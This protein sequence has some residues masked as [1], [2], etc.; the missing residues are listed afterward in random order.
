[1]PINSVNTENNV[2]VPYKSENPK[3][4]NK[5]DNFYDMEIPI[6]KK[7]EKEMSP[8]DKKQQEI[9]DATK[10]ATEEIESSIKIGRDGKVLSTFQGCCQV[11][12]DEVNKVYEEYGKNI[13]ELTVKLKDLD[14]NNPNSK[15]QADAIKAEIQ[16]IKAKAKQKLENLSTAINGIIDVSEEMSTRYGSDAKK[17]GLDNMVNIIATMIAHADSIKP[18]EFKKQVEGVVKTEIEHN[19]EDPTK[20]KSSDEPQIIT[21]PLKPQIGPETQDSDSGLYSYHHKRR[22]DGPQRC[23]HLSA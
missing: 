19:S 8:K 1:M 14:K 6:G 21:E 5:N 11:V 12:T 13:G 16:Q 3:T 17:L 18:E 2:K 10:K 22:D 23:I 7:T 20:A 9:D 15:A 4:E